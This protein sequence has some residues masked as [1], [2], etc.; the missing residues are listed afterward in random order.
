MCAN[1]A[2]LLALR[3][4]LLVATSE[5]SVTSGQ[6]SNRNPYVARRDYRPGQWLDGHYESGVWEWGYPELVVGDG[7]SFK[8]ATLQLNVAGNHCWWVDPEFCTILFDAKVCT[9]E[10]DTDGIPSTSKRAFYCP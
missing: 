10:R 7:G 1:A 8:K 9:P 6:N 5:L 2:V 3:P 4:L